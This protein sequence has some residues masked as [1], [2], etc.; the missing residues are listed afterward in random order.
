[1]GKCE[2]SKR[3]ID[4]VTIL[5]LLGVLVLL[6]MTPFSQTEANILFSRHITIESFLVRNIFQYF[7]SDWSMRILFFL[8]SVGS[9]VLYRSIL[10]SYFEKNSSYY[11]LALLIFILLPGVTLSF[12]LVN[13]ATI[14][15]FLTL[16]IVYSYKKEFNIL[17]VLAMVLLLFTH[18]AQFVIYLA[19]VLYSYQK[20]RW[21][22]TLLA[23]GFILLASSVSVYEI[24]G[25]PRGHL[26]QLVGI[27]AAIFS[28]TLFL[29]VVYA[30]YKV[31]IR[32][33]K[34]ILWYIVVTALTI[35]VLLSIRQAIKITDFAP[36]VVISIPLVVTVFR[37]SLAIRLKEFRKIYYLVCNVIV[38][39]LLL[40]TSVIFLHYP[41]YRYTPVKE[42]LLDTSIYEIPQIVEELKDKGKVCKD[43]IS[44]KDYTL[45]LYYGVARCP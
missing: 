12:I 38:L 23:I 21:W 17:L 42:L 26:V 24:D 16:L 32:G 34:E 7:H 33:D 43:E 9:I 29:L 20:K 44:K 14:P 36:F 18:S 5:F 37:D 28:P 1:M 3:A 4:S 11:N 40:E 41:L 10:E 25:I 22:L 6:F 39:V 45:Y 13:Y 31:A 30:V 2:I 19:I 8:F 15:I 27:Y 35:S